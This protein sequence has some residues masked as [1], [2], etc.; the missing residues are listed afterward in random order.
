M[1]GNVCFCRFIYL[2][3]K[4]YFCYFLDFGVR[5]EVGGV[6][7]GVFV[8]FGGRVFGVRL[9]IDAFFRER[10]VF[11]GSIYGDRFVLRELSGSG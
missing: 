6:L 2:D 4:L 11:V 5:Y 10:F 7:F 3:R 9:V 1:S 8:F